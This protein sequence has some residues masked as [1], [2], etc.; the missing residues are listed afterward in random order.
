MMKKAGNKIPF[1]Y[2]NKVQKHNK[3]GY[4]VSWYEDGEIKV[5]RTLVFKEFKRVLEKLQLNT[6]VVHLRHNTVGE[7]TIQNCH[8][9]EIPNG[10]M[11]HN[12]TIVGL[13]G[14]GTDVDKSDTSTL[15]DIL[16]ECDYSRIEDVM[17]LVHPLVGETINRLVFMEIDGQI[18]IVNEDLGTWENGNWYSNDYHLKSTYWSRDNKYGYKPKKISSKD[19]IVQPDTATVNIFV[20]GTLKMGGHNHQILNGSRFI[21]DGKTIENWAMIGDSMPFPYLLEEDKKDGTHIVGEIYAVNKACLNRLDVLEGYPSHYKRKF[22]NIK[23]DDGHVIP[24]ITYYKN[25]I[26]KADRDR[27]YINEFETY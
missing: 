9:F 15:A 26:T 11:F 5:F 17:P 2:I 6:C 27:L 7:T 14:F 18:T 4:G 20:Y 19:V 13:G 22:V 21:G 8:P 16:T 25:L 10:V 24:C 23:A 12:G 3:D 1:K